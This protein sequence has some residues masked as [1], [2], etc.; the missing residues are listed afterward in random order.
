MEKQNKGKS[1]V[2]GVVFVL[3]GIMLAALTGCLV[4]LVKIIGERDTTVAAYILFPMLA[5]GAGWLLYEVVF[6]DA[7]ADVKAWCKKRLALTGVLLSF[8]IAVWAAI[9]GFCANDAT[10]WVG[11]SACFA[12][13]GA[14]ILVYKAFEV[15]KEANEKI[16]KQI[17]REERRRKV[18]EFLRG[19]DALNVEYRRPLEEEVKWRLGLRN[20]EIKLLAAER[21]AY[22]EFVLSTF[23]ER[24]ESILDELKTKEELC[25]LIKSSGCYLQVCST[26]VHNIEF[27]D[28]ISAII[29]ENDEIKQKSTKLKEPGGI[30][31]AYSE[32][33]RP[34]GKAELYDNDGMFKNP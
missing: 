7:A 26:I 22:Y 33:I 28:K 24:L 20:D 12:A 10:A 3:V 31:E 11:L 21:I 29:T 13:M 9:N 23:A 17:D 14:G 19:L 27:Y 30:Y 16:Q 15:Q 18:E 2:I 32:I 8:L 5:A 1:G 4:I 25:E 34:A 6:L